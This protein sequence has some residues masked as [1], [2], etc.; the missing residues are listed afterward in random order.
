MLGSRLFIAFEAILFIRE[1]T[2]EALFWWRS[3]PLSLGDTSEAE[4]YPIRAI[5]PELQVQCMPLT[6]SACHDQC[7]QKG[8][9]LTQL[10]QG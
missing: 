9:F 10:S 8:Q 4:E 1:G 3:H 5:H 6:R 7:H 2:K